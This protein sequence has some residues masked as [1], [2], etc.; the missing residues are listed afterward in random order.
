MAYLLCFGA[1]FV[2]ALWLVFGA[3]RRIVHAIL[4]TK[5]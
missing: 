1:G 3:F 5:L 4:G 2:T